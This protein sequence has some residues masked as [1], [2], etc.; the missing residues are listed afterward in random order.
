MTCPSP[1]LDV[2]LNGLRLRYF[3]IP[4]SGIP[5]SGDIMRQGRPVGRYRVLAR[6]SDQALC[7]IDSAERALIDATCTVALSVGRARP[8]AQVASAHGEPPQAKPA[9]EVS[10]VAGM[11]FRRIGPELVSSTTYDYSAFGSL[12]KVRAFLD[13]FSARNGG[14]RDVGFVDA[15]TIQSNPALFASALKE[16]FCICIVN[17]RLGYAYLAGGAIACKTVSASTLDL[18]ADKFVFFVGVKE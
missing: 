5:A 14:T 4:R 11:T 1:A 6:S 7:V 12:E 16:H 9:A 13:V 3:V 10:T 18:M 8:P 17:G 15:A 2:P